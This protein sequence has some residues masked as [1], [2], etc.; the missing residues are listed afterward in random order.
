M[1]VCDVISVGM[2]DVVLFCWHDKY[3]KFCMNGT[4]VGHEFDAINRNSRIFKNFLSSLRR[5]YEIFEIKGNK[6]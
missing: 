3:D 1:C 6:K 2:T 5:F 4:W